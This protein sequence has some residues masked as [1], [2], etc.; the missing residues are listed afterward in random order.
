MTDPIHH[1]H[2]WLLFWGKD[3]VWRNKLSWQSSLFLQSRWVFALLV[4]DKWEKLW[5]LL[6]I[7]NVGWKAEVRAFIR[8][9]KSNK[10]YWVVSVFCNKDDRNAYIFEAWNL[11]SLL[12]FWT[13]STSSASAREEVWGRYMKPPTIIAGQACLLTLHRPPRVA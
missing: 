4:Q 1:R 8:E 3:S 10:N 9:N 7:L 13:N 2:L 12:K 11:T 6:Q 5:V